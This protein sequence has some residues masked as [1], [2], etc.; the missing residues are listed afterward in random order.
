MKKIVVLIGIVLVAAVVLALWLTGVLQRVEVTAEDMGPFTVVS[1]DHKGS[2]RTIVEEITRVEKML[3]EKNIRVRSGFGEYYDDPRQVKTEDLRSAGGAVLEETGGPA[4]AVSAPFTVRTIGRR[5]YASASFTG[6]PA[7]GALVVYPKIGE[8][9]KDTGNV[10]DGP[11]IEIYQDMKGKM[12][13][14]YLMPFTPSTQQ[15]KRPPA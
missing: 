2:Y 13:V 1:L 11:A 9:M 3:Q 15:G 6:S 10:P 4:P 14:R 7:V 5:S 8:W 12:T